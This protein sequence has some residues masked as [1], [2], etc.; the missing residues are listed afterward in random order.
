M[1]HV[2]ASH[3]VDNILGDVRGMTSNA[4]HTER[5]SVRPKKDHLR[6]GYVLLPMS[7]ASASE[8]GAPGGIRTPDPLLRRQTLYPTEL[9][10]R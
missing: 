9:R 5:N 3:H 8:N 10:A 1:T 6:G 4:F 7:P 2:T